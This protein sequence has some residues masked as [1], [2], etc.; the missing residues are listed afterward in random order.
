MTD[1]SN[2]SRRK[3]VKAAGPASISALAGCAVGDDAGP[4]TATPLATSPD[5]PQ[6]STD[7]SESLTEAVEQEA[8]AFELSSSSEQV[9]TVAAELAQASIVGIGENSHGI[10]AFK[11]IPSVLVRS[12]VSDHGY[13]LVAI[14][15]TLGDFTPVNQY[16][17]GN[18]DDLDAAMSSLEFYFWR[19]DAIKQMF[20]WLR[21]FNNGR[22]S[23]DRVEVRG[24]DAQF[25]DINAA[26]IRSY[27]ERVDPEYL[28]D[29]S[30]SLEPLTKPLYEQSDASFMTESQGALITELRTR[31][32][33]RKTEYVTQ[34][35]E[36]EWQLV[37][38]HIWTLERGLQFL[39]ASSAKNYT[40]GKKIRDKAMAENV[41]WLRDWTDSD[42]VVVMGNSNHTMRG[43]G[44]QHA[45]RMGEHLTDKFGTEYYSL[46]MLFGSGEFSAPAHQHGEF[47][48]YEIGSAVDNTLESTLVK[49]S[50]TPIFLDFEKAREHSQL[51]EWLDTTSKTQFTVPRAADRGAVGLSESPGELFDGIVFVREAT[52]ASFMSYS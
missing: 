43:G 22:S 30:D 27:L 10:A 48:T 26:A 52:A 12:L 5:E 29:I 4:E 6:T 28:A 17:H 39:E 2:I 3:F 49:I 7:R 46:G 13:R 9:D 19:T 1:S 50:R 20:E 36:S 34:S 16:I 37:N 23:A 11:K 8:V 24:Y 31:F 45:V 40:R 35:S 33:D 21:E 32:Q 38:R 44:G 41:V 42:R 14:E 25:H 15:G 18:L 47:T 51:S